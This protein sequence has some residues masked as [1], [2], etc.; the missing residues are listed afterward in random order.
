MA[1]FGHERTSALPNNYESA[2]SV[3][4][5]KIPPDEWFQ[6]VNREFREQNIAVRQRPFLALDRYCKD[7]RVLALMFD[8]APSKAIF[9]WFYSNTKPESHHIGSLFT[10][11]F[12]Y[13]ACF[14]PVDIPVGYGQ[15]KLEAPDSLRGIPSSLKREL[16]LESKDA[17]SF[18]LFWVDCIDYGYGFDDIQKTNCISPFSKSLM[19]NAD[20][21][22]RASISQLLEHRPNPKAAM[23]ARMAT[24]IYLKAFLVQKAGLSETEVKA[25]NHRLNDLLK[26]C[27]RIEP[28]HDVLKIE[29]DLTVFPAI[30]ER[31]TGGDLPHAVL[32]STYV[33]AQYSATSVVRSFTDR[34]TRAQLRHIPNVL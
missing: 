23:S 5:M 34:D 1:E 17:R 3:D 29:S 31:Y 6:Q 24:E 13:D 11:A 19:M 4:D 22:L 12:Y 10:G 28:N 14:W 16:M 27:R 9:D 20:R 26:E 25:F 15:F 30:H 33:I 7:F 21:E 2:S 32:W 18:A 8:S